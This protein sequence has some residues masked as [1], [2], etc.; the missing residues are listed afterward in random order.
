M[1]N[2]LE[3][4][5]S[6]CSGL[7]PRGLELVHR[8]Q[9]GP[10]LGLRS[11]SLLPDA[12]VGETPLGPLADVI[13]SHNSHRGSFIC[14]WIDAKFL[15]CC[16][17]LVLSHVQPCNPVDCSPPGSSVHGDFP[18][19]KT[20]VNTGVGCHFLLQ[21]F[22]LTLGSNPCLLCLLHCRWTL[23]YWATREAHLLL[24]EGIKMRNLPWCWYHYLLGKYFDSS[25]LKG[26]SSGHLD[27]EESACNPGDLRDVVLIPGLGR[28]HGKGNG[29]PLKYSCLE[30][31]MDRGA[32]QTTVHG[33]AKSQTWLSN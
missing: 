18:G 5:F 29:N 32:C 10:Q 22:I 31:P 4:V 30:D 23:C 27:G 20:G 6:R 16:C 13:R 12:Q 19:K 26:S 25:I 9:Q 11:V 33:V 8:L 24:W 14:G 3:P 2:C 21:G 28:S 1:G 7:P 17:C 15:L